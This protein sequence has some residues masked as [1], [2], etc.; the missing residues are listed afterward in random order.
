MRFTRERIFMVSEYSVSNM[1][2]RVIFIFY[3]MRHSAPA[4][5]FICHMDERDKMVDFGD[6]ITWRQNGTI[7]KEKTSVSIEKHICTIQYMIYSRIIK[8]L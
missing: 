4:E 2:A 8:V 6:K 1:F 7:P 5:T 3:T